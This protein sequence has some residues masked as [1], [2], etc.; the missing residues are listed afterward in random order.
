MA[1]QSPTFGLMLKRH[2]LAGGM[3]QEELAD[4]T[5]VSVR[6]IGDLERG[7]RQP[8]NDTLQILLDTLQL[9][10]DEAARLEV[11]ARAGSTGYHTQR[12]PGSFGTGAAEL[13]LQTGSFLGALPP[14]PLIGRQQ[15]VDR[16]V[17]A[18][19]AVIG[20][21]ARLVLL[22]GEPGIGKTRLAQQIALEAAKRGCLVVSGRCY[23]PEQDVPFYP[24]LEALATAYQ[25]IPRAIRDDIPHRWPHLGALLPEN[26]LQIPAPA[27]GAWS[28]GLDEQQRLFRAVGGF[29]KAISEDMPVAML[30]DDLHW[31]DDASLKL[32]LHLARHARS[33]R[34]L[35]LGTYR[36]VEI[37]PHHPLQ[38]ALVDLNRER[39]VE[40]VVLHRLDRASTAEL[41]VAITE[42]TD[43][44]PDLLTMIDDGTDGNPFFI[45][46]VLRELVEQGDTS[47]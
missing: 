26:V 6:A 8:R 13:L 28:T 18:V 25:R 46:E 24:F 9:A 40:R 21:G 23:E 15:E 14:G 19:D 45:Q 44:C 3:T 41:I 31:A 30:L 1:V 34:L 20:G 42:A 2:R 27:H 29:L 33:D 7:L 47:A 38:R 43:V 22:T 37:G 12:V 4:R 10:P 11:A 5:G 36:D 39:L 32:V 17:M 16:I 35:L